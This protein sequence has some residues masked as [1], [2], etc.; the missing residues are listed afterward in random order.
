[1]IKDNATIEAEMQEEINRAY[2]P[3]KREQILRKGTAAQKNA[4]NTFFDVDMKTLK[5][6]KTA[7]RDFQQSVYDYQQAVRLLLSPVATKEEYPDIETVNGLIENPVFTRLSEER[8]NATTIVGNV[9]S[10]V[11]NFVTESNL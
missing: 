7:D 9:S 1:M 10:S 11:F 6:E 8:Q 4:L 2:P 3:A 5:A